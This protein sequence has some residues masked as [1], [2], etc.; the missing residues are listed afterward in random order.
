MVDRGAGQQAAVAPLNEAMLWGHPRGVYFLAMTE[1]WERFSFYG[2]RGLL[3][4]YMVQELLLPGHVENVAGMGAV[5]GAVE[6]IFGELSDQAFASQLFGLY[7][8]FVYFTPLLG[9]LLADKWLGARRTVILGIG[10]MSAGHFAMIWEQSVLVALLLLIL[11]SGCLKGNIAAQVGHLYPKQDEARRSKGFT[12]FS[13][14]INIGAVIGPLVCGLLAQLYGWHV[15][16]G[17]AGAIMLLAAIAYFSGLKYLAPDR[18]RSD[19]PHPALSAADRKMMSM[20]FLVLVIVLFHSIAFDQMFNVGMLGVADKVALDTTFGTVPVPWFASED[21]LASILAVPILLLVWRWQER[22]GNPPGDLHKIA[23]GSAIMAL[24]AGMLALGS[25]TAGTGKVSIVYPTIA[26]FLSGLSF[27][28]VWPTALALVSRR[29]P[30]AIN[31]RMMA[32]AYL[33]VFF[34]G[35]ISGWFGRFYEPLPGHLFWLMMAAISL[36]GTLLVLLFGR[37]ID[38][39]MDALDGAPDNAPARASTTA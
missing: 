5:R 14:G 18:G 9:G 11:G 22:R 31:A 13:T 38:A 1:A 8:G 12:I 6:N 36:A 2:M 28:Y 32:G 24:S 15:G 17:A 29:S 34:S 35:I 21:S 3:V 7:A 39:R 4:L 25:L 33:V 30:P 10:L 20:V 16:F 19:E 26:F 37:T 27:M 23:V